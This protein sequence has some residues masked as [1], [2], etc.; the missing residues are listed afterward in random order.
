M[1]YEQLFDFTGKRVMVTGAANGIGEAIARGFAGQGATLLLADCDELALRAVA[2]DLGASCSFHLYDQSDLTS[3]QALAEASGSIDVLVNNAGVLVTGPL[4]D[5]GWSDLRR[6]VDINLV[7]PIALTQRIGAAMVAQG[8]GNVINIGSQLVF[9]GARHRSVY[10]SAKAGLSQFTKT[11]ALEWGEFGVRV[12]CLAPGKTI[13]NLNRH[14]LADP[15]EYEAGLA[16]TP[17][18]R[19]GEP[20]DVANAALFMASGAASYITG[21]T[22]VIDG[23]WILE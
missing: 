14:L 23:G 6:L 4:V 18:K 11:A 22:L 13:T 10:A 3:V 21:H 2:D 5:L 8:R 9:N 15:R 7:G 17:I 12:N 20:R 16:R 19:Y 1:S